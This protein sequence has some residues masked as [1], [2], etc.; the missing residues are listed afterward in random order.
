MAD[1]YVAGIC[2]KS[3]ASFSHCYSRNNDL[4]GYIKGSGGSKL[5]TYVGGIVGRLYS[6]NQI[7]YMIVY[8]NKTSAQAVEGGSNNKFSDSFCPEL[9]GTKSECYEQNT[10]PS[11]FPV[12]IWRHGTT[13]PEIAFDWKTLNK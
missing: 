12:A 8:G 13:G 9:N 7:K 3:N 4:S 6:G 1:C 2:G 10:L 11:S 5:W